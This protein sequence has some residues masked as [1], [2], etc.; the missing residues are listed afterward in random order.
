[1]YG[2]TSFCGCM[3]TRT[4]FEF[5]YRTHTVYRRTH[6]NGLFLAPAVII[7]HFQLSSW[8][9]HVQI[10]MYLFDLSHLTLPNNYSSTIDSYVCT[11]KD[12]DDH[13]GREHQTKDVYSMLILRIDWELRDMLVTPYSL[14]YNII[15]CFLKEHNVTK[16]ADLSL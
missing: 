4:T 10:P 6:F 7:N 13:H 9:T 12:W 1:M 5:L 14:L 2:W 16:Y 15:I 8:N 3:C 11:Y